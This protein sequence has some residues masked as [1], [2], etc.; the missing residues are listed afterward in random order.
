MAG[1]MF[2]GG[3]PNFNEQTG[4]RFDMGAAQKIRQQAQ[5][6][7]NKAQ[8]GNRAAQFANKL[9][10][11]RN[12]I[13][14][15][16]QA[17]G[18]RAN[19]SKTGQDFLNEW[20]KRT[21]GILGTNDKNPVMGWHWENGNR[22]ANPVT[23]V[24]NYPGAGQQPQQPPTGSAPNSPQQ[25]TGPGYGGGG[26]TSSNPYDPTAGLPGL[27]SRNGGQMQ[28]QVFD[29]AT[30]GTI[31]SYNNAANRLRERLDAS[32]QGQ[33]DSAQNRMLSRGFG[34]SGLND[35]QQQQ[36][37]SNNQNAYAQGLDTL[38]NNFEGQRQQG[39]QTASG[40]ANQDMQNRNFMDATLFGLINNREQRG[41]NQ[42]IAG[43]NNQTATNIAGLNNTN[44]NWRTSLQQLLG[45]FGQPPAGSNP[46]TTG[47]F[48]NLFGNI[49]GNI[50][51]SAGR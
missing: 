46:D 42:A 25:P 50:P 33:M 43:M 31:N 6:G 24:T 14:S 27:F 34:N 37:Q 20:A 2:A 12:N 38:E 40:I 39:L 3:S 19:A 51:S 44:E 29:A 26:P 10:D 13:I 16:Q 45:Q 18:Q 15:Q 36:I 9:A 11:A 30:G 35:A 5:T 23:P 17:T 21:N 49:N 22:V 32:A 47:L 41:S 28:Q 4:Q 7:L 8:T 48:N 1:K